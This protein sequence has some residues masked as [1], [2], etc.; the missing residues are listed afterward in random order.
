MNGQLHSPA[1]LSLKKNRYFLNRWL[2]RSQCQCG[3][4]AEE[5]N[6]LLLSGIER[7]L[8]GCPVRNLVAIPTILLAVLYSLQEI[9]QLTYER[10]TCYYFIFSYNFLV[11]SIF[12]TVRI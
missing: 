10:R 1:A 5:G 12:Q 3:R 9:S 4:F 7:Q 8:V 2:G 6:I 11:L